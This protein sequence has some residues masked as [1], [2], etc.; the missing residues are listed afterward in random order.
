M[1]SELYSQIEK[2]RERRHENLENLRKNLREAIIIEGQ[3]K[4]KGKN[5]D[6]YIL[7]LRDNADKYG[8][9]ELKLFENW[10]QG[11]SDEQA[12]K[13]YLEDP[14]GDESFKSFLRDKYAN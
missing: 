7:H 5:Y 3:A 11:T 10:R 14:N 8:E 13:E 6:A 1:R 2:E 12:V 4:E 9:R